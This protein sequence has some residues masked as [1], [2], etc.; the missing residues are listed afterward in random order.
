MWFCDVGVCMDRG[1]VLFLSV[2]MVRELCVISVCVDGERVMCDF[3][4]CRW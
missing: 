1:Y 3:Y 4:L 2:W